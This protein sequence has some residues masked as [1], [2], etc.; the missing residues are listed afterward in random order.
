[1]RGKNAPDGVYGIVAK[2]DAAL[3]PFEAQG[4]KGL[5]DVIASV[6]PGGIWILLLKLGRIHIERDRIHASPPNGKRGGFPGY[7]KF[8]EIQDGYRHLLARSLRV[9]S[10]F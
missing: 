5:A 6:L 8:F 9:G 3:L 2:I 7:R 1:L 4:K 10:L